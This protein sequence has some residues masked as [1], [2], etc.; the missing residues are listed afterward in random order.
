MQ[1]RYTEVH[2]V[3]SMLALPQDKTRLVRNPHELEF[4]AIPGSVTSRIISRAMA[5]STNGT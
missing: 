5:I 2:L 1:E 3:Q 4:E